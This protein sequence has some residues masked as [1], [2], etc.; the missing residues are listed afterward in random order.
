MLLLD[1]KK[2]G[3]LLDKELPEL[4]QRKYHISE[5]DILNM[6]FKNDKKILDPKFNVFWPG[7]FRYFSLNSKYPVIIHYAGGDKPTSTMNK[8]M[9]FWYW[10][11]VSKTHFYYPNIERLI[12]KKTLHI[13]SKLQNYCNDEKYL[14]DLLYNLKRLNK[15]RMKRKYIRFVIK[16][17]VDS[18]RYKK[19]KTNPKRFF[20][21]SQ[22]SVIRFLG[23][24]YN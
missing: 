9:F 20:E 21:D 22:S 2:A 1:L 13:E 14:N 24:F 8:P 17:L 5:Q 10:E 15:L 11:E 16:L 3:K 18:K 6:I 7:A 4:M 23:K 19:L 12:D